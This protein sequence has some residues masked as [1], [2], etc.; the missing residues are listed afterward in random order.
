MTGT[1]FSALQRAENSSTSYKF[2]AHR[3]HQGFSALQRAENSSTV[4]T[5]RRNIA[6]L[7]VSVLFSEPK[8]PQL[9]PARRTRRAARRV[10]VLFSEPKIPQLGRDEYVWYASLSF[11]ALQRAENSSTALIRSCEPSARY[12]FSALQRAENSSTEFRTGSR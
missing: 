11:S 7:D 5:K 9:A 1:R 10:S 3:Q 4:M 12:R 2:A 6:L 8:I